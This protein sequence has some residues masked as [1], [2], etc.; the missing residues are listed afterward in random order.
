MMVAILRDAG[1][2]ALVPSDATLETLADGF[3]FTEGPLWCPD[4]SLLFQDIKAE[5]TYRVRRG[6]PAELVRENTRAANGQT[7]AADGR[8]VFCEQNGRRVSVMNLD[9]TGVETVA[10]TWSGRRLNSPNDTVCRSD[11]LVYFTDPPYGVAPADRELHFQGVYALDPARGDGPRLLVDDFEKPNGLAFSPDERTL[12]ICD[13]ARYHVRAFEVEPSGSLKVGSSRVFAKLDPEQPGGPDG[14]KVDRDGRV[15]VAV[16]QG[17]W[18]FEPGGRLLGILG[19]PKRPA[20]LAWLGPDGSG[21]AITAVDS[22]H[23]VRLGVTGV[24]PVFTPR[25]LSS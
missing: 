8:I 12:Y 16:A 17:V 21:L 4:D 18:V 2:S 11:G 23:A 1:L 9:G 25:G 20:N 13:T 5:R 14:M 22:V 24:L 10:E 3:Q 19:T 15:Y 6:G 7:F